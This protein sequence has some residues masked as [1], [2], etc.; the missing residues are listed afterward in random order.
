MIFVVSTSSNSPSSWV[1]PKHSMNIFRDSYSSGR[2]D[3][4]YS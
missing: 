3:I 2:Q 1:Q 4:Q